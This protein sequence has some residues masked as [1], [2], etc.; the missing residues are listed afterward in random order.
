LTLSPT[1]AEHLRLIAQ[2]V[3][4]RPPITMPVEQACGLVL[5]D[6]VVA[7]LS[8][9]PFQNSAV[10]GYAVRAAD[11][12]TATGALPARLPVTGDIPA[13]RTD[14]VTLYPGTALRIMTGAPVPDGADAILPVEATDAGTTV[15]AISWAAPAGSN[16]RR[17]GEDTPAGHQVLAAGSTL[18]SASVGLLAALGRRAVSVIPPQRVLVVSAGSELV[19]PGTPLQYGQIYA[20]NGVMLAA[21]VRE[22]GAVA[23]EA[24]LLPDDPVLLRRTIERMASEVDLVLTAGGIS[25]GAYEVVKEALCG[26]GVQFFNLAMRPGAPQ[27]AGRLDGLPVVSVPGNPVSA[28]ISFEVLLREPLRRAMGMRDPGRPVRA[29]TVDQPV[30]SK[31]GR[32]HFVPAIHDPGTRHVT[33]FTG[34]DAHALRCLHRATCLID[35]DEASVLVEPGASVR[36]R[37]LS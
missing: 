21:A 20:S 19:P 10:D 25:A 26:T 2:L 36:A 27:G 15:V 18:T 9:P 14:R 4:R 33:A 28:W 35:V 11:V 16:I 12:R 3:Q 23:V 13:G 5:A 17:V 24:P 30:R 7:D 34:H 31:A 29:V 6:D 32:R 22:A 8:L 1:V 37:L